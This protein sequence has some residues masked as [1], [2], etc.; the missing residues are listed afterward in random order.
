MFSQGFRFLRPLLTA[1]QPRGGS[2]HPSGSLSLCPR[3]R[4]LGEKSNCCVFFLTRPLVIDLPRIG[5]CL[6]AIARE[7][8]GRRP[9]GSPGAV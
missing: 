5:S 2:E 7:V 6:G 8:A 9:V 4:F 3:C 1:A